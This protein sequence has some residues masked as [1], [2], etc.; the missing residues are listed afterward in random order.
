MDRTAVI[1]ILAKHRS[2]GDGEMYKETKRQLSKLSTEL[3]I[4][5]LTDEQLKELQ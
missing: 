4:M 3:L 1:E 2:K 5:F